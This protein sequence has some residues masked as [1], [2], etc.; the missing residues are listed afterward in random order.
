[1]HGNITGLVSAEESSAEL[2]SQLIG[3]ELCSASGSSAYT[4]E[5]RPALHPAATDH[6][7]LLPMGPAGAFYTHVSYRGGFSLSPRTLA[8][9]LFLSSPFHTP[10]VPHFAT[11]ARKTVNRTMHSGS[12]D[13]RGNSS[14][15]DD[16]S[17]RCFS[18]MSPSS[19]SS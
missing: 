7:L 9:S 14:R 16:T 17:C 5:L 12:F 8:P 13:H 3:I 6:P 4:R 2:P 1:M 19:C 11:T 15:H 18:H 10:S